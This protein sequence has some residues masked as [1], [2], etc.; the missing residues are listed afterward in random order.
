MDMIGIA[1][2][3]DMVPLKGENR[4]I[5]H[6][7]KTVIGKS[8]RDGLISILSA[9]GINQQKLSCDDIAFTIGPRINAAGRLEHPDFAF[10]A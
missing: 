1:T 2:I 10:Y 4:V 3:C 9:G 8:S 6:F 5:A 7:A